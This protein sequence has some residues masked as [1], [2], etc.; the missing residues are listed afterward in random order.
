MR[1]V[2]YL[3]DDSTKP[4]TA[5]G[6]LFYKMNQ[7]TGKYDLLLIYSRGIYEDFG[8]RTD[9]VDTSILDTVS[10]EVEEESNKIFTK[11]FVRAGLLYATPI[12]IP[13]SKYALFVTELEEDYDP[14]VFG[15]REFHDD[16]E[17]IVVWIDAETYNNTDFI[18]KLHARLRVFP[19]MSYID[20]LI[21]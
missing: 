21:A 5:G 16:I 6:V 1:P 4:V 14:A 3:D 7:Q 11:E 20:G 17:R 8:G 12:Y 18:S 10:R 19:V 13:K 15:D 2:F 9:E